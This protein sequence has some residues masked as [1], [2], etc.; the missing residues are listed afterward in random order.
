MYLIQFLS[1]S[2]TWGITSQ[3]K[4]ILF[5]RIPFQHLLILRNGTL[6]HFSNTQ[7]CCSAENSERSIISQQIA[8]MQQHHR[9]ASWKGNWA[10]HAEHAGAERLVYRGVLK[11]YGQPGTRPENK[12]WQASN[13]ARETGRGGCD[14]NYRGIW[15]LASLVFTF[16]GFHEQLRAA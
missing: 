9:S 7:V 3:M 15:P 12:R 8:N 16:A 5:L 1:G 11:W 10:A 2:W 14:Y 13:L 4:N 6:Y